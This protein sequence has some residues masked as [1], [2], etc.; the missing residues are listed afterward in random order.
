MELEKATDKETD[1]LP[2]CM[3][4]HA[5]LIDLKPVDFKVPFLMI[6]LM[7]ALLFLFTVS[8]YPTQGKISTDINRF[9]D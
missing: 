3:A 9:L 5:R 7:Y 6:R 4:A 8:G 2:S 1:M